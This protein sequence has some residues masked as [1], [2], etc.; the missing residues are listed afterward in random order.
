MRSAISLFLFILL[1]PCAK[2]MAQGCSDAGICTAGPIKPNTVDSNS[3]SKHKLS[4]FLSIGAGDENVLV[5]TPALQYDLLIKKRITLQTKLTT[6]YAN[7]NLGS[8]SGPGDLF[9]S[10]TYEAKSKNKWKKYLLAGLK[11]PLNSSNLSFEGKPLPMQYQSSLGTFDFLA[12]Y[13]Y[14]NFKWTIA[15]GFQQPLTGSNKNAFLPTAWNTSFANGYP[16]TNLFKR[17]GDLLLR[18]GYN[19]KEKGKW[20]T[21]I[22]MLS[23]YHLGKDTYIDEN[24]SNKA[25]GLEGSQGLTINITAATSYQIN[26]KLKIGISGGVPI[27]VRKIRPDGLTRSFVLAPEIKYTL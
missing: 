9:I 5:I 1:A 14:T 20:K 3:M 13:T 12:G 27:I 18:G 19:F 2:L 22:G 15:F 6:N 7:G 10:A 24:I 23:I 17:K 25:V 4:F 26:K 21:N 16:S 11:F 8:A